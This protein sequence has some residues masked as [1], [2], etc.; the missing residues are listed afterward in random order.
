MKLLD[1]LGEPEEPLLRS[2]NIEAMTDEP[3]WAILD[4]IEDALERPVR[5]LGVLEVGSSELLGRRRLREASTELEVG[6]KGVGEELVDVSD[7]SSVGIVLRRSLR[8]PSDDNRLRVLV[9]ELEVALDEG[10]APDAGVFC[11]V[12]MGGTCV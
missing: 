6:P 3:T 11:L 8:L 9:N 5:R 7:S 10:V 4:R 12:V 2:G 1:V